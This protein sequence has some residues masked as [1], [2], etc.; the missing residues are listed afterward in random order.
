MRRQD[1][2]S[3]AGEDWNL[4]SEQQI[5]KNLQVVLGGLSVATGV[6]VTFSSISE[7]TFSTP[8]SARGGDGQA[9]EKQSGGR[10]PY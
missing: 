4:E 10:R 9:L 6:A 5:Y 8:F 7:T 3:A 1:S 2:L